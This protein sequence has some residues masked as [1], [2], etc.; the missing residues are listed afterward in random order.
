MVPYETLNYVVGDVNYGGRVTDYM[1]QRSHLFS[2]H[3]TP[4]TPSR[5]MNPHPPHPLFSTPHTLYTLPHH[6]STPST[7]EAKAQLRRCV[8]AILS[9]YFCPGAVED[10]TYTF[11]EVNFTLLP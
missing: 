2:L 9:L 7:T 6:Q 3:P 5:T 8:A 1:D 11:S 10:E 4:S